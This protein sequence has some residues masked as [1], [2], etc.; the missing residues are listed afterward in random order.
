MTALRLASLTLLALLGTGC[1]TLPSPGGQTET[2]T[3]DVPGANEPAQ[4]NLKLGIGYMQSGRF[5]LAQEKLR[6]ALQFDPNLAEAENALGVMLEET[7]EPGLAERH[8][9]RALELRP[10]YALARMNLAR[11]LCANDQTERGTQLFLE[12]AESDYA[13]PEI[14][15]TGAGVCARIAGDVVTAERHFRQAL[16]HNAYAGGTLFELASLLQRQGRSQEAKR[17]L[18]RF[19]KRVS[20]SPASLTLA[21]A[22]ERSLGDR[23]MQQTYTELLKTR[24]AESAEARAIADTP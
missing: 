2:E 21:I 5:P 4:V 23:K 19:H 24:F 20:F 3:Q 7:D 14:P 11:M 12:V 16:E 13:D 9:L 1:A 10:D 8:Y 6:R 18:D 17:Y 22:I 15:Y